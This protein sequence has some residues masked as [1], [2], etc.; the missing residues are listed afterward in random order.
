MSDSTARSRGFAPAR[1]GKALWRSRF[2]QGLS[3]L[4]RCLVASLAVHALLGLVFGTW[5]VA[6]VIYKRVAEKPLETALDADALAKEKLALRIREQVAELETK[7]D[8]P[9]VRVVR[10]TTPEVTEPL[11]RAPQTPPTSTFIVDPA[12][13]EVRLPSRRTTLRAQSHPAVQV[14]PIRHLQ[15]ARVELQLEARQVKAEALPADTL[16]RDGPRERPRRAASIPPLPDPEAALA[17][18]PSRRAERSRSPVRSAIPPAASAATKRAERK[19]LPTLKPTLPKPQTRPPVRLETGMKPPLFLLRDPK[20]RKTVLKRLGGDPQTEAAV[21]RALAWLAK[22][23]EADGRWAIAR[24]GGQ[25]GHDIASTAFALLC[26]YG[27]GETHT[28]KGPHQAILQK[29]VAWLAGQVQQDGNL[30][31]GRNNGMYDQGVATL[32]LAEAY[33]MTGDARLRP[34]LEKAVDFIVKAQNASHGGW[35]YIP[36]SSAGDTSVFGWQVMALRSAQLGGLKVPPQA[37]E[38]SRAWLA[39]VGAGKH[40]GLYGYRQGRGNAPRHAMVA[41]GMFCRLMMGESP[42][43]ARSH[44]SARYLATAWP[45]PGNFNFY[46]WYYGSLALY[47]Q[48]GP[49]WKE[50]N[51]RLKK[52]LVGRQ[53]REGDVAGSWDPVGKWAGES[54]RLVVTAMA[55]LSLEVY[56]RYL[57][58]ARPSLQE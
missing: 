31:G 17:R 16:L 12:V 13:M 54:G 11:M 3:L 14:R 27:W 47:Q 24:F 44:E 50:W 19:K 2:V 25:A 9:E 1:W 20:R 58:F 48:Q 18:G 57:P 42:G 29:G 5:V 35:R 15:P 55:T 43:H 8:A 36:G 7:D 56:Y 10:R 49:L 46:Y 4:Q 32:A 38:R 21:E 34:P 33:A 53:K 28:G 39:R 22:G 41:E 45:D 6:R 23:Q 30:T 37:F 52:L 51:G 26:F 40:G